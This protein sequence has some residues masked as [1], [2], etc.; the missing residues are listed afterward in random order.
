MHAIAQAA[1]DRF[2]AADV[3]VEEALVVDEAPGTSSFGYAELILFASTPPPAE[4]WPVT[5]IRPGGVG[6]SG[7]RVALSDAVEPC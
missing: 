6:A 1:L 4:R 3:A 2:D 5:Q 7:V